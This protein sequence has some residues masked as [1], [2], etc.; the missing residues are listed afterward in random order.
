[1]LYTGSKAYNPVDDSSQPT[2]CLAFGDPTLETW[3]K[4]GVVLEPP[5]HLDWL[6]F[7]DPV[8][9]RDGDYFLMTVGAGI[10]DRGGAVLLYRSEDLRNWTM[11][12]PM[13]VADEFDL[14]LTTPELRGSK[15]HLGTVWECPQVLEFADRAALIVSAWEDRRGLYPLSV[16]G[17]LENQKFRPERTEVLDAGNLFAPLAFQD[18]NDR[19]VMFGW[20][21]EDRSSADQLEAGWSGCM[22]L[23]RV[24]RL[25]HAGLLEQHPALELEA[26]RASHQV[27]QHVTSDEVIARGDTLEIQAAFRLGNASGF[28]LSLRCS[29][30][31]REQTRIVYD[32]VQ[33][34]LTVDRSRSSLQTHHENQSMHLPKPE[35]DLLELRVFLDVSMLEVF[36]HGRVITTR[37]YPTLEG[38]GVRVFGEGFERLEMWSLQIPQTTGSSTGSVTGSST[39][40]VTGSSTNS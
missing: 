7:R 31:G 21:T 4:Q 5:A 18:A 39:G 33:E 9:W 25:N 22:S 1:M 37:V 11:L 38:M 14:P 32:P 35:N 29:D 3:H 40:S 20:V 23:P 34:I 12:E 19:Q 30:D 10:R 13:L 15:P 17:S 28:G 2:I 16:T 6:G 24:L 8:V 27:W 26:L 36:A